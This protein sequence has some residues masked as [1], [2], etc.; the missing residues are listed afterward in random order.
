MKQAEEEEEDDVPNE[1]VQKC[2]SNNNKHM[3]TEFLLYID[4]VLVRRKAGI[5]RRRFLCSL[6]SELCGVSA[7]V[8]PRA[9]QSSVCSDECCA[10]FGLTTTK[11]TAAAAKE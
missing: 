11:T 4:S 2:E 1:V 8:A 3:H 6:A 5:G 7:V 9:R 10:F